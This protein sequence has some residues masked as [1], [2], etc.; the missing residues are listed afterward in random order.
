MADTGRRTFRAWLVG[1]AGLV[2][3]AGPPDPAWAARKAAHPAPPPAP[4]QPAPKPVP[5]PKV[6][7]DALPPPP[8]AEMNVAVADAPP[9]AMKGP[10]GWEG[11]SVALWRGIAQDLGLRF[12][13]VDADVKTALDGVAGG[14]FDAAIGAITVTPAREQRV[15]FSHPFYSTGLGIAVPVQGVGMWGWLA[16]IRRFFSWQF[17]SVVL[18]LLMLLLLSGFL[19]WLFERKK[20][21]QFG[22]PWWRGIGDGM[23]WSAV[24]MTTVG[25]GD[26]SPTTFG[27]RLVGLLWMFAALIVLASFTAAITSALTI[28]TMKSTV[29]S[30]DDLRGIRFG[31]VR[32]TS[33][34]DLLQNQGFVP[35]GYES[36]SAGLQAVAD[37]DLDAFVFDAPLLMYV[38]SHWFQKKIEVLPD[39]YIRQDYGIAL[40][41]NNPLRERINV[42]LLRRIRSDA[43]RDEVRRYLGA[44][45]AAASLP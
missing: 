37:G 36:V 20:N 7:T 35:R 10:N 24:T 3:L 8:P 9:F 21:P 44:D 27:G 19:I 16:V 45:E 40:R 43:W 11:L 4:T 39:R 17:L 34:A 38:A 13:L 31:V 5:V 41:Q 28:G 30:F 22:G 23:W 32:D 14:H 18:S 12:R 29:K 42:S 25:Y 26:K 6:Q 2:L 33:A 15:D 1:I